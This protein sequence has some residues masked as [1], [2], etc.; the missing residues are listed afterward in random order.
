MQVI[1]ENKMKINNQTVA[2]VAAYV[3]DLLEKQ[4]PKEFYY[5][6]FFHTF[7]VVNASDMLGDM[8]DISKAEKRI[9][10]IAAWFHD[11]GYTKQIAGHEKQGASIAEQFL[12]SKEIDDTEIEA[13]KACILATQ[14][15]QQ[16]QNMLE[17]IICDADMMHVSE[18]NFMERSNQLRKEWE[19]QGKHL[20]DKEWY[21]VNINFMNNHSFHTKYCIEQLQKAKSKNLK[22]VLQK[23]E[24]LNAIAIKENK[25]K[26]VAIVN[27]EKKKKEKEPQPEKGVE[28]FFRLASG[29]HMKLSDM[30]DNKAHILLSI[31]SIIISV[32]LSFLV[33]N[34]TQLTYLILPTVFLLSV[35]VVTTVFAVLTTK[36]KISKG[37]FTADQIRNR[38]VNLLF[39]GN[40]HKMGYESYEWGV[41]EMMYDKQYLY[42]SMTKDIYFLGKVLAEKYRYLNIG[43]KVF[44]FGL[45]ASV[46]VFGLSFFFAH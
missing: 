2:E 21:Q 39:F 30:A 7:S 44:M 5:H 46:F 45:I 32:V 1:K 29:N 6:D 20:T 17:R 19:A 9:V 26:P 22:K 33:K 16:P 41:Q 3:T 38:E 10:L 4:L 15:P 25:E 28:T 23:M 43:Y 36:P 37:V 42:K 12:K 34:L 14:F 18:P 27:S 11:T 40:F 24:E 13:V 8:N 31:N 35:C